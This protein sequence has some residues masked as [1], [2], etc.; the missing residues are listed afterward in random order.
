MNSSEWLDR[1][2]PTPG[3][4]ARTAMPCSRRCAA[5]PMPQRISM[6]G[7]WMPPRLTM[8]SR[9]VNA[10]VSPPIVGADAG[11]AAAVERDV[12][13][14]RAADD[15]EIAPRADVGGEIADRGRGPL[16]R[17]VA[18]RRDR[19]AVAEIRVHVGDER[20][21][22]LVGEALQRLGDRR[23]TA[24]WGDARSAPARRCRACRRRSPCR[25]RACG[26]TAAR[27]SSPSRWRPAA[28]HSA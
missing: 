12:G 22:P 16:V 10:F 25:S 24:P 6:A 7:E 3:M 13:H 4:S 15:G 23:P 11:G 28:S 1:L 8:I 21:L 18:D 9:P 2:A 17:P 19:V 5:G 20:N 26:R 14:R 27:R